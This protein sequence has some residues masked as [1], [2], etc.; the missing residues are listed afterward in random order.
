MILSSGRNKASLIRRP[1]M[2]IMVKV[3][4]DQFRI[5]KRSEYAVAAGDA[6]LYNSKVE[7]YKVLKD[8]RFMAIK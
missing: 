1:T 3:N 5:Y 7:C 8:G 2:I 4:N 6:K